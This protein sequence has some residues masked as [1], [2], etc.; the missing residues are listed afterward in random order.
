MCGISGFYNL[1]RGMNCTAVLESMTNSLAH[2]GNEASG[3]WT[4]DNVFL[5]H[6]RLAI[7]DLDK[8]ANQPFTSADGRYTITYDG[9]IYNFRQ[10]RHHVTDHRFRTSSDTEVLIELW[11]RLGPDCLQL[12]NGMFAFAIWDNHKKTLYCVRDRLGIKPLYFS[13]TESSFIF[14]S[15]AK[16]ILKHPSISTRLNP[17]A[18]IDFLT[19][20]Y[21]IGS[22]S[23][24][25][26]INKLDPGTFLHFK[27]NGQISSH[28]YWNIE[29][30]TRAAGSVANHDKIP[31]LLKTA[32]E[33]RLISDVDLGTFLSAGVDSTVITKIACQQ[34]ALKASFSIGFD[35]A[36]FDESQ[37]AKAFS[38]QLG[39]ENHSEYFHEP[40]PEF[41][42]K[43]VEHYDQPFADTSAVAYFQL[44]ANA[45][46]SVKVVLSGDGG[47]ELFGGYET[48]RADL[49]AQIGQRSIP[50]WHA[51]CRSGS[52]LMS[53]IKA[54]RGKVSL[55]Y[56]MRQFFDQA[57]Y[58]L[59]RSHF[60]WR[61][62]FNNS[63]LSALVATDAFADGRDYDAFTNFDTIYS[64]IFDL[65]ILKQHALVDLQTWLVD[66]ILYK[67]DQ[68]SMAHG[69]E[70][71][72]PFLDH[73]L[74]EA[75]MIIPEKQKFNLLKTKTGL[76]ASLKQI[77]PN[78]MLKRKKAGFN[79]P[80][81][82][83]LENQLADLFLDTVHSQ[84]FRQFFPDSNQIMKLYNQ[85]LERKADQGFKLWALLMFGLW[86][87]RWLP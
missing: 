79:S 32:V 63:E 73:R 62:L 23:I 66:D 29:A 49:L 22:K 42:E 75:A 6:Q 18:F 67:S 52:T 47:D 56:K 77:L 82:V 27:P 81:S 69:L 50:F 41:L 4:N 60:G 30:I 59:Q 40:E 57:Q 71:R 86:Q 20:G 10:L 2:R 35:Q 54:D 17:E 8:R 36:E 9:I 21:V 64:R 83:W 51:I 33:L 46:K 44:C 72:T 84:A 19:T 65:P 11:A 78:E 12:L 37:A 48:C 61:Q 13:K 14:A 58:S 15:E 5:G 55:N 16:A 28:K 1:S 3:L 34:K 7:I 87:K 76:R 26:G 24:F 74:V 39:L 45:S 70:T 80:V 53:F 25:A 38:Q 68:G 43:L 31:E 85:H